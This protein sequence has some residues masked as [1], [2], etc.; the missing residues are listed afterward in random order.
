LNICSG[1][2]TPT[3]GGII[4][5]E[6]DVITSYLHQHMHATFTST[7]CAS[8]T[9]H[10]HVQKKEPL[11]RVYSYSVRPSVFGRH[12]QCEPVREWPPERNGI[13]HTHARAPIGQA[14]DLWHPWVQISVEK[15]A[16]YIGNAPCFACFCV[17]S[18]AK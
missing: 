11:Y 8:F 7:S 4:A 2:N 18:S 10:Q 3:S 15:R 1:H 6:D 5:L 13:A 14:W 16:T 12:L 9:L 17:M